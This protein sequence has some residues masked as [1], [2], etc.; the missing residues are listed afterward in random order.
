VDSIALAQLAREVRGCLCPAC[1]G[2]LATARNNLASDE[3]A[4]RD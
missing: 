1:L 2:V 3:A 4:A